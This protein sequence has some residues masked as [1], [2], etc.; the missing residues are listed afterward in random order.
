MKWSVSAR[1][2]A[3][4]ALLRLLEQRND[5]DGMDTLHARRVE[6]YGAGCY[7]AEYAG[8]KLHQRHDAQGAIDVAR[9][10]LNG[11]CADRPSRQILGLASYAKWAE[12]NGAEAADAL[13]QGRAFLPAGP[14]LLHLL[15]SHDSTLPAAKKLVADGENVDQKDNDGM[16]ALALA[17]QGDELDAAQRLLDLGAGLETPVTT[18]NIPVALLPVMDGNYPAIALLRRAGVDYSKLRYRGQTAVELVKEAV[19]DAALLEAMVGADNTR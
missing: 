17:L 12:S 3:Y 8:F 6:E 7:A 1:R 11:A 16:T 10:G 14:R 2:S 18:G 13:N 5:L 4:V 19:N 9:S 15:A